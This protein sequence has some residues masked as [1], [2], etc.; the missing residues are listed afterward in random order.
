MR[1]TSKLALIAVATIFISSPAFAILCTATDDKGKEYSET[2]PNKA[3]ATKAALSLCRGMS[4]APNS[5]KIAKCG[6]PGG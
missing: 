4:D 3:L 5:C 1:K 6:A 2:R